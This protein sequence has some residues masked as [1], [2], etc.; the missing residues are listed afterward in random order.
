MMG[1][2]TVKML[3]TSEDERHSWNTAV[4]PETWGIYGDPDNYRIL[5]ASSLP[6]SILIAGYDSSY[7][8]AD[9]QRTCNGIN[10]PASK[11]RHSESICSLSVDGG[12]EGYW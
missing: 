8:H 2:K 10:Y 7:M 11:Q 1:N 9:R 12:P 6:V 3:A 5:M 4:T